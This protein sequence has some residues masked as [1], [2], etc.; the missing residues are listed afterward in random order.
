MGERIRAHDWAATPFGAVQAW[1]QSLRS[2]LSIC[3]RSAAGTAI[4]WGAEHLFLY[5]DVWATFLGERHPWALGRKGEEVLADIWPALEGHFDRAFREGEAVNMVDVRLPRNLGGVGFDSWWSYS[6]L[7]IAGEDGAIVGML[8]QARET[9]DRVLRRRGDATM[10]RLADQVRLLTDPAEILAAAVE[11]IGEA[12]DVSRIG[13]G[14]VDE[15]EGVIHI[16]A[17]RAG[18]GLADMTGRYP[19]ERAGAGF[20]AVLGCGETIR[21]ADVREDER[22]VEEGLASR[23]EAIGIRSALV[24]PVISGDR[25]QAMLFAHEAAPRRWHDA[26]E[27]LLRAATHLLWREMSRARAEIA[28]RRSE[29]RYRRIF[30]QANDILLTADVDQIITDI[31]PAAAELM[32][33]P[34]E[35]IVGRSIRD[36][37]TE[38]GFEQTSRM[39][40]DKLER[41]GTTRHELE[42][43]TR[44]GKKMDWEINSALT[45]DDAGRPVGLHAIGRDV[46]ERR[47]AEERQRLL[48]NELNHRVKNT[49]ALVQG[50]ALQSFKEG[51]AEARTAFQQRLAALAA[52]HD[53]LTRE[54]WEGATLARLVG[55]AV[56]HVNSAEP[57]LSAD[58]PEVRLGPKAAVS[59]VMALHELATNAAKYGALSQPGGEVQM[60]W[61][62]EQDRL[63]IG[64]REK[65]G[66]AVA[67]PTRRGFGLRMIERAL[68][69]DLGGSVKIEF[70]PEGLVCRIDAPLPQ[71]G[72]QG[73]QE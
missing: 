50:I 54:S 46:T 56:G 1:P 33:A 39:L 27:A 3:L 71:A 11:T 63:V 5:N 36:F 72:A 32:E 55:D 17:C 23:Y 20:H 53:L 21:I 4:F 12:L 10:L 48:V 69:A 66:P 29:E 44:S 57:R 40:R 62:V 38:R 9:T 34:R 30:E 61:A 7:P 6:L 35:E 43:I 58:G 67:P 73:R 24:V 8:A 14:E 13:Y 16:L 37:V 18:N 47:R 31:N 49:L 45:L 28:L 51:P 70:P 19:I 42:V 2:A 52:A 15:A 64:W 68:A 65:G 41:G 26:E 22:M 59:L 25:Y 60:I